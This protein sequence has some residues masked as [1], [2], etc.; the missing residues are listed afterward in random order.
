MLFPHLP[1]AP[2]SWTAA[3]AMDKRDVREENEA[4]GVL[5]SP[6]RPRRG[7]YPKI[8]PPSSSSSLQT[9]P[10][11]STDSTQ[12]FFFCANERAK[13]KRAPCSCEPAELLF[14]QPGAGKITQPATTRTHLRGW[15]VTRHPAPT[16]TPGLGFLL[17]F[18]TAGEG[19]RGMVR[20]EPT[21]LHGKGWVMRKMGADKGLGS[22]RPPSP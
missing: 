7:F 14:R 16:Q 19:G 6:P 15:D 22:Y 8:L 18:P 4:V 11:A 10:E 5:G 9:A 17:S 2:R 13:K 1:E 20:A 21:R 12:K 3:A